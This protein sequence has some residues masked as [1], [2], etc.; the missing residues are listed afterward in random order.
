MTLTP[1]FG[2]TGTPGHNRGGVKFLFSNRTVGYNFNIVL[3][4]DE[5]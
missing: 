5:I 3:K 4:A 2:L 1:F